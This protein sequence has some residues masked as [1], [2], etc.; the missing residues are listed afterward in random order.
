MVSQATMGSV[1]WRRMVLTFGLL[2]TGVVDA[3]PVIPAGNRSDADA[4][5]TPASATSVLNSSVSA[6]SISVSLDMDPTATATDAMA[7]DKDDASRHIIM[8][9]IKALSFP[10]VD[11]DKDKVADEDEKNLMIPRPFFDEPGIDSRFPGCPE[12]LICPDLPAIDDPKTVYTKG[13]KS[14]LVDKLGPRDVKEKRS[15][16][17]QNPK[18][19]SEPEAN[20]VSVPL[21]VLEPN[22][23]I[24]DDLVEPKHK[25]VMLPVLVPVDSEVGPSMDLPDVEIANNV[26]DE[27]EAPEQHATTTSNMTPVEE[28]AATKT[29][30]PKLLKTTATET[31]TMM[32]TAT[33][34]MTMKTIVTNAM[35]KKTTVTKAM[36]EKTPVTKAIA[37]EATTKVTPTETTAQTTVK[38]AAEKAT[39]AKEE[40]AEAEATD[41]EPELDIPWGDFDN[42]YVADEDST[43]QKKNPSKRSN[44]QEDETQKELSKRAVRNESRLFMDDDTTV[45][46]V[47]NATPYRWRRGYLHWYQMSKWNESWPMYIEP[48]KSH[49]MVATRMY[50]NSMRDSAAEVAYHLE[51][52]EEPMSFM[53]ERRSGKKHHI[54]VRFMENLKTINKEKGSEL[55]LGFNRHPGGSNFILAGT[56]GD[57]VS[58]QPPVAWMKAL[59]PEIG[60]R[61]LREIV[62]PRAHH[63]GMWNNWL[64]IGLAQPANTLCQKKTVKQQL[65]EEGVRVLDVRPFRYEDSFHAA[66]GTVV[67]GAWNGMMGEDV[68][69]MAK[70]V[71]EFHKA[72][73]GELVIIDIP[74][75]DIGRIWYGYKEF[76][77]KDRRA[78]YKVLTDAIEP[79]AVPDDEDI[80]KWPL[81]RLIGNGTSATLIRV[82]DSWAK[83]KDFPGGARGFVTHATFPTVQRWSNENTAEKMVPDQLDNLYRRRVSR[84]API[85]HSDWI[86]TQ[87]AD[88]AVFPVMS[89]RKLAVETY[90]WMYSE[91]WNA[92]TDYTYPNWLA[93]DNIQLTE[94]SSF[95]VALNHCFVA[96]K[97]GKLGGKVLGGDGAMSVPLGAPYPWGQQ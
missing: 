17:D 75:Y 4:V 85:F 86:L 22:S 34:T 90:G 66:H 79:T 7:A 43:A 42:E 80:T 37:T 84:R 35:I 28:L 63:A 1:S 54:F 94:L 32:I 5:A 88:D 25:I 62:M 16:A 82:D 52:T 93:T 33:K 91:L 46:T 15:E 41:T 13:S 50:G 26:T 14:E 96:R 29:V 58:T 83:A 73:P 72:W 9:V 53:V 21:D 6:S 11:H 69:D 19:I 87:T 81:E 38:A 70:A 49:R 65:E 8:D 71:A 44:N 64:G 61:P 2:S 36:V 95:V 51:G 24:G 31:E 27:A 23:T 10:L 77:D 59:L 47:I 97:C 68:K 45:I 67:A 92:V 78:L 89:I 55:D 39:A 40:S 60:H 3:L 48:G 12:Y 30:A 74:S 18:S 20:V 76:R 57:F 56:E